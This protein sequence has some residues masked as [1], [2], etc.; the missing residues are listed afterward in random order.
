[1]FKIFL[2]IYLFLLFFVNMA[3]K[4]IELIFVHISDTTLDQTLYSEF[5]E[6][7]EETKR[8]VFQKYWQFLV[9]ILVNQ[10]YHHY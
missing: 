10:N 6:S 7:T 4:R 1:M 9:Q 8:S 3:Q 2:K 5:V